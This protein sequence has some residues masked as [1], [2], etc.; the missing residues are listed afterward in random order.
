M[1]D[2]VKSR[3]AECREQIGSKNSAYAIE[4]F[5]SLQEELKDVMKWFKEFKEE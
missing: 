3:L 5:G 4:K 2:S 1:E